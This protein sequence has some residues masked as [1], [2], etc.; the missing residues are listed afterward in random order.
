MACFL[1]ASFLLTFSLFLSK[2]FI[3]N[4]YK[5]YGVECKLYI[6]LKIKI[7]QYISS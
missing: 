6:Y 2:I 4:N 5:Y 7:R 3:L 1:E